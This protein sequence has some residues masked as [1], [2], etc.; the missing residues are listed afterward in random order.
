MERGARARPK[1]TASIDD[2]LARTVGESS[3]GV[4]DDVRD[5]LRPLIARKEAYFRENRRAILDFELH[6]LGDEWYLNVVSTLDGHS[7]S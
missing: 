6:D 4:A 7:R 5:I 1:R 3:G 2:V